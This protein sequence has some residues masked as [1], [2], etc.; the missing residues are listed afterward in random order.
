MRKGSF[1]RITSYEKGIK[2][3]G[4]REVTKNLDKF[5]ANYSHRMGR[6]ALER[7]MI[8]LREDMDKVAPKIPVDTGNLRNSWRTKFVKA[9]PVY[10]VIFGF[11][12]NYALYVHEMVNADF[13]SPRWRYAPIKKGRKFFGLGGKHPA[14]KRWYV[15]RMGAGAK[16]MET[17]MK[18]NKYI[19]K[20]YMLEEGLKVTSSQGVKL[21]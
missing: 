13:T 20:R 11:T 7:I 3:T 21:Y 12:A 14:V 15:P 17:H 4:I 19:F 1:K 9:G 18:R 6:V 16:F 2:V 10:G 8:K 5:Y